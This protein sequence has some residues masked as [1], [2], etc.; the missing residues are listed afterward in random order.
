MLYPFHPFS[1]VPPGAPSMT[2]ERPIASMSLHHTNPDGWQTLFVQLLEVLRRQKL[3]ATGQKAVSAQ[4]DLS[5]KHAI[6]LI[7]SA[8]TD[9]L[10][11]FDVFELLMKLT[12]TSDMQDA[13]ESC[14]AS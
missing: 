1:Q 3:H 4:V 7:S 11:R 8:E 14:Q 13:I 2:K 5:V 9:A 6:S 12:G 10:R